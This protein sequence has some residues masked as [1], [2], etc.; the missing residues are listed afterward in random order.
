M[1]ET[2]CPPNAR[3]RT[4][5]RPSDRCSARSCSTTTRSTQ[6]ARSST[7]RDFFRD[8]H[9]RIFDKMVAAHRARRRDRPRHAEGGA[10]ALRRAR[11]GRRPGLHRGARRRRAARRPTSST[12]RASSRRR[13]RSGN[14]I[15]SANKILATAYEAEEDAEPVILDEAEQAIFAIAEDRVRDGLRVAAGPGPRQLRRRSSKLHARKQLVT[16][17]PTGFSDLDEMTS[18]LQPSDLV[19]VAARPVDGQDEPGAQHRAA[20]RDQD[21]T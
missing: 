4:T 12:T 7:P 16:G 13:R 15:Y 17:V 10:G 14:L 19:I 6:A 2:R 11:R 9:R 1:A 18:G 20:R 8:A 5:S 3:S 21:R